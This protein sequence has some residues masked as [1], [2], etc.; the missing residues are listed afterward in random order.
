M[1]GWL[2][3]V[4]GQG[5]LCPPQD[6]GVSPP[7]RPLTLQPSLWAQQPDQDHRTLPVGAGRTQQPAEGVPRAAG[8]PELCWEGRRREGERGAHKWMINVQ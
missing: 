1:T 3:P 2:Q 7:C 8:C 4:R 6:P 5:G